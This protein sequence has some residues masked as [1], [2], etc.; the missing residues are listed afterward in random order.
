MKDT[1]MYPSH[2]APKTAQPVFIAW[3]TDLVKGL[4]EQ[5][6]QTSEILAGNR[7]ASLSRRPWKGGL[8][9]P[10][11]AQNHGYVCARHSG[12]KPIGRD[13]FGESTAIRTAAVLCHLPR[14]VWL[15]V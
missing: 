2:L 4:M 13:G 11:P 5:S 14:S 1:P 9:S 3:L 10:L 7:S 6:R 8:I 12:G 15:L